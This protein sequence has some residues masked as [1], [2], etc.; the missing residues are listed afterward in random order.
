MNGFNTKCRIHLPLDIHTCA[1]HRIAG[2]IC[3]RC[4]R[5]G[6][7]L[8]SSTNN[9]KTAPR[10]RTFTAALSRP[11]QKPVSPNTVTQTKPRSSPPAAISTSVAQPFSSRDTLS[12]QTL[13]TPPTP[14]PLQPPRPTSCVSAGTPLR[15]LNYFKNKDDPIALE[16]NEYPDWL[17]G[18]L[19]EKKNT[20]AGEEGK[21][22]RLFAKS[23]RS[24]RAANKRARKMAM[25]RGTVEKSVPIYEQS[26]DLEADEGKRREL[27]RAMRE[28]RR[29]DIKE[30]NFLKGMG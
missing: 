10:S 16:D 1:R 30:S 8:P 12:P 11:A 6:Y 29:R 18:L 23:A 21:D 27:T 4:I 25:E 28:K 19:S 14:Q 15:G 2:M 22:P 26:V 7:G 9:A 13:G 5:R 20:E 17:W 24:R 3:A